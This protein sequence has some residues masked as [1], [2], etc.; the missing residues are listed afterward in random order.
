MLQLPS[1][2]LIVLA[3]PSCLMADESVNELLDERVRAHVEFLADD[4][5]AGREAGTP[6]YDLAARYVASQF[7]QLALVPAGNDDGYLHA[8]PLRS[9]WLDQPGVVLTWSVEDEEQTFAFGDDY[10]VGG[11]TRHRELDICAPL[12]F[13]GY[14]IEAPELDHDD[15]E[16]L[17]AAGKI[18]V[19]LSQKPLHFPS[20]EGA[21]FGSREAKRKA[22]DRHGAVGMVTIRTPRH[23]VRAPWAKSV[24]RVG[25]PDM[26]WLER[27]APFP[28]R[29]SL[30]FTLSL[31]HES[32]EALF[33]DAPLSL[34][35]L[36]DRDEAGAALQGF[37]LPGE[38]RFAQRSRHEDLT[39]PNVLALFVGSDPSLRHEIVLYTAHL[40]AL[41]T[42]EKSEKGD[43]IVNGALDNA[44]G[45][46]V[47]LETARRFAGRTAPRRSLMFAAVTAEEKGL[48]GSDYLARHPVFADREIVAV[49]NLDMPLVLYDFA[50]VIAFGAEHSTLSEAV[51]KA[52]AAFDTELS[53]D[54]FP[55]ESIFVRS[56]HYNFVKQGIPSIF[57]V[58]GLNSRDENE[59]GREIVK[60]FRLTH[61]HSA[62]DDVNLA[63]DFAAAARFTRINHRIGEIVANDPEA[64]EWH[65][66]DFFGETFG[67]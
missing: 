63:I 52:A 17:D 30:A 14:G 65:A 64:P 39:S 42:L 67:K 31:R 29:N 46:A 57:V 19:V 20:E 13:A 22:A 38:I 26:A 10:L 4:L 5:L 3:L 37:E 53:P 2:A 25:M 41:G 54:P 55:E 51:R 61:Y 28:V 59:D 49:I 33:D 32:A 27:N 60:R 50:D 7:R 48:L 16:G 24:A 47:M 6:G 34:D 45:V 36:L 21:H 44:A 15:Y 58:T 1:Y 35:E 23:D 8:V 66:G 43:A 11:N 62:T 12:L 18:V 56:D 9:A 40:D